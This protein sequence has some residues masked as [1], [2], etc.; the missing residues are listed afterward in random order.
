MIHA[1]IFIPTPLLESLKEYPWLYLQ[2]IA[3]INISM[4][5]DC[6]CN[7]DTSIYC[8]LPYRLKRDVLEPSSM[9][10]VNL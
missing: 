1:N 4:M 7:C 5:L 2:E 8:L 3:V 10:S 9:L 6:A